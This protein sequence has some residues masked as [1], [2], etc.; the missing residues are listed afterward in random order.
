MLRDTRVLIRRLR[1]V[2]HADGDEP[3]VARC[4]SSRTCFP[5]IGQGMQTAAPTEP[6]SPRSSCPG[7]S[8]WRWCSRA[9][10]RWPFRSRWSSAPPARSRTACWR[11]F[12]TGSWR[13]RRSSSAALQGVLAGLVG[14]SAGLSGP[15]NA[16]GR[17]GAQL[18]APR[19]G[20]RPREPRVGR[21]GPGP[22]HGRAAAAHRIDV[23]GR[24]GADDVS[25]LRVLPLGDAASDPLA[26]GG[27][28]GQPAGLYERGAPGRAHARPAAHAGG[29]LPLGAHRWRWPRCRR[30]GSSRSGG[31]RSTDA[32]RPRRSV[33]TSAELVPAARPRTPLCVMSR[34]PILPLDPA[35][36]LIEV[37]RAA[38]PAEACGVWID[39]NGAG[40]AR[41]DGAGR[42][43]ARGRHAARPVGSRFAASG[44]PKRRG[45]L[46]GPGG[47]RVLHG[48]R[49]G[50]HAG[51]RGRRSP[52][53]GRS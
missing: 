3:A 9:S 34:S 2:R 37:L 4:S 23:C 18:A 1:A 46:R 39:A 29:S 47:G 35:T 6:T 10:R 36:P 45:L 12:P 51:D 17:A 24:R 16:G 31:G 43:A 26:A 50:P 52:S 25:R 5:K 38:P 27:G 48:A 42:R 8:P 22:R 19:R 33:T 30:W 11:R 14:L 44:G 53:R 41:A 13:W 21:A 32:V 15:G 49:A 7:S 20:D 28:A 40:V